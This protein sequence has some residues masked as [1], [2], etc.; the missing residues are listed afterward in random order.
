MTSDD[1]PAPAQTP[2]LALEARDLGLL[3]RRRRVLDS[4]SF[5][6]PGGR[7][8]GLI[9]PNGAGKSTLLRI[10]S[11]QLTPDR[12]R[13]RVLDTAPTD[14][15]ALR[16]VAWVGQERP[17][18]PRFTVA[19]T[20]RLGRELNPGWDEAAAERLVRGGGITPS[21]RVGR[22]SGGQQRRVALALALGKRPDLLLLD[23]PFAELDPVTRHEVTG[24]LLE[25]VA[26][27]GTTVV[28]ASHSLAEVRQICDHLLVLLDGRIRIS[29]EL[30]AVTESHLRVT[31]P[32][33]P[34]GRIPAA[35]AAHT[36]VESRAT[37]RRFHALIRPTGPVPDTWDVEVP[38]PEDVL[39]TCL[40]NPE[41]PPLHADPIESRA[42]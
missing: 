2:V 24:V 15:S 33:D 36:V 5:R 42:L 1:T 6:V 26:V 38:D 9:G 12:G 14:P 13:L 40:R 39:L 37:G 27:R 21:S 8:S 28:L 31:G 25:E 7:V 32:L 16:R 17:L 3:R 10:A 20:L 41:A 18:F 4:C 30:D 29:G 11:G 23:E 35:L 19:E 34:D 22:L